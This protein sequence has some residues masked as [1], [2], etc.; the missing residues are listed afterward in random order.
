MSEGDLRIHSVHYYV[1]GRIAAKNEH[2]HSVPAKGDY[3]QVDGMPYKV[4]EVWHLLYEN[5]P[6][7]HNVTVYLEPVDYADTY[8]G[9][10]MR[11]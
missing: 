7:L 1:N 8:S 4:V 3:V 10:G 11:E 6:D 5:E 9:R 2:I